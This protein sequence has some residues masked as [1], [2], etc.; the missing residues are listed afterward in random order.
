[1]PL[2]AAE[3]VSEVVAVEIAEDGY[4]GSSKRKKKSK[5]SARLTLFDD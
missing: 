4:W 1:M 2:P 3:A 5:G